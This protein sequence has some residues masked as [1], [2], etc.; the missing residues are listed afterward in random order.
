MRKLVI[1]RGNSG[2]GKSTVAKEL[3]SMLGNNTML[4]SQDMVRREI[5]KVSDG[6]DTKAL[7]L[8]KQLLRYGYD[9]SE[10]VILEGI[11]VADWYR[12]LF[13]LAVSLY[14]EDVY[15]YYF[16]LPFE[17]TVKRHKT[18][19]K[20]GSFG[21]E[22]MREWWVEKDYSDVLNESKIPEELSKENIVQMIL[23]HIS[24]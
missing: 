16:D 8:L 3:Q 9:H 23:N 17:E 11:M 22:A 5:L 15:A 7:P 13:E 12:P 10:V 2:S 20:A 18:R 21:E 1:L 24:R 14:G 4:I 19:S 6:K